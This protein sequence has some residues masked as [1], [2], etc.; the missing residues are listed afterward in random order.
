MRG[1]GLL[2]GAIVIMLVLGGLAAA[3]LLAWP[4][5]SLG[6]D[7]QA[8]ASFSLP[9]YAGHVTAVSVREP[10]G[11]RVPVRVRGGRLWPLRPLDSGERLKVRLTVERPGWAGWLVGHTKRST[12]RVVTPSAQLSGRWLQVKPGTAVTVRFDHPVGL[13]SLGGGAA[14]RFAHP[15][16]VVDVNVLA[17]GAHAAGAIQVAAAART[18]EK[19]PPPVK[20]SW[21]PAQRFPQLLSAPAPGVRLRPDRGLTLTFSSP[22]SEVLG[23]ERPSL[24]RSTPGSWRLV[25]AHTLTFEPRG[26][27]FGLG[28]KVSLTL[29]RAV[30]VV[31]QSGTAL[32]RTLE[33][34]VPGGSTLRLQQLLA[35]LGYLR[36]TGRPRAPSRRRSGS[37]SPPRSTRR[38]A[39]SPGATRTPPTSSCGSGTRASGTRSPAA[40]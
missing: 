26:L 12:F 40:R 18:W 34:E 23:D 27:G 30:H 3:A 2:V 19:L 10:D 4:R 33:W 32:T 36:S 7:D 14:Q 35:Q 17:S 25:D 24:T 16:R 9:G 6:A 22:V 20:V 15:R 8:L 39:S 37:S 38:R 21:F 28:T 11:T 31:G 13:V 29:P 5:A 1:R